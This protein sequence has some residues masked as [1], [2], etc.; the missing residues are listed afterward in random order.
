MAE[1]EKENREKEQAE[2]WT[3]DS[4]VPNRRRPVPAQREHTEPVE[5]ELEPPAPK[6]D[7]APSGAERIPERKKQDPAAP[8]SEY[9]PEGSL[10]RKVRVF[11]WV[12]GFNYYESFRRDAV[13]LAH[14]PPPAHPPAHTVFFSYCPQ[15]S[16]MTDAQLTY[17][18]WLRAEIAAGRFPEA[19]YSYILLYVYELIN[20]SD[21]TPPRTTL[22]CLCAVWRGY[23]KEYPHLNVNLLEWI[24]DFCLI[25]RFAPPYDLL[26]DTSPSELRA[27]SLKEFFI[28]AGGNE[29]AALLIAYCS[30]YDYRSGKYASEENLPMIQRCMEGAVAAAFGPGTGVVLDPGLRC[31]RTVRDAYV[32]ALCSPRIRRR[33]EIE[34]LSFS[35]SH[36]LRF[37][38]TDVMKY[39]ENRLRAVLGVKSRLKV[40]V[41]PDA[42]RAAVDGCLDR[43]FPGRRRAPHDAPPEYEKLYEPI[44]S[45]L[46]AL[47]LQNAGRIEEDSWQTTEKLIEAFC[48]DENDDPSA[49]PELLPEVPPE[50]VRTAELP[51]AGEN[52]EFP[53][54]GADP[55]GAEL[56]AALGADGLAFLAACLREDRAEQSRAAAA[57]GCTPALA[58]DGI[59]EKSADIFGDI[60]LET[61]PDG[62]SFSVLADYADDVRAWLTETAPAASTNN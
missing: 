30:N 54:D 18:L 48:P 42:I 4:L 35:H 55:V 28:S 61:A 40:G 23:H 49:S 36:E 32:G 60:L 19:D 24:C 37:L 34:F 51:P 47:S 2:F 52:A 1:N 31:C 11:E 10:L 46:N 9:S 33:I 7:A 12:T 27:S 44:R 45:E 50:P 25:H 21:R 13:R 56:C 14:L 15:Y 57:L 62:R 17:Y 26:G 38:V 3:I 39:T 43:E 22:E 29:F 58:A 5:M 59:N 53:A 6:K 8:L 41:L 20:L 16:Q